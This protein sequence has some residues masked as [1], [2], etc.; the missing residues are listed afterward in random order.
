MGTDDAV[1][2]SKRLVSDANGV[3]TYPEHSA[4]ASKEYVLVTMVWT[5]WD[6]CVSLRERGRENGVDSLV[7]TEYRTMGQYIPCM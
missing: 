7:L 2:E 3:V 1:I 5:N 4:S 6:K